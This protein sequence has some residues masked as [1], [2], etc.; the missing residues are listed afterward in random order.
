MSDVLGDPKGTIASARVAVR[1]Y[2]KTRRSF[3]LVL[4]A[5]GT[6]V[7]E[8]LRCYERLSKLGPFKIAVGGLLR[9]RLASVR[10]LHV[11]SETQ[12]TG[13]VDAIRQRFDPKWMF[14]LGAYHPARHATF[15]QRGV[16]GSDYKGWIFQYEHRRD[17]LI[18]AA[19]EC[20][21]EGGLGRDLRLLLA[22]RQRAA[23]IE[24]EARRQYA[25]TKNVDA[26]SR[27]VKKECR[28]RWEK[29]LAAVNRADKVLRLRVAASQGPVIGA[30]AKLAGLLV[31]PE[32]DFRFSGVH[33]YLARR[34]YSQCAF[35][36]QRVASI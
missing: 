1:E 2:A 3:D 30:V 22:R 18:E 12:M 19:K 32:R 15:A 33:S 6:T 14:V 5:Q 8:Y 31:V 11:G 24:S 36:K 10:Y 26:N 13:V 23:G 27:K 21:R 25:R 9:K 7:D 20:L 29:A 34:V 16:F 28:A 35:R 4:V 17:V